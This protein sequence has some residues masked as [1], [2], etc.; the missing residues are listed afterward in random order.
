M[1]IKAER[2]GHCDFWFDV[3][4]SDRFGILKFGR[5]FGFFFDAAEGA[6]FGQVIE[7]GEMCELE[8][9]ETAQ[10]ADSLG[11]ADVIA[12][13]GSHPEAARYRRD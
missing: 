9:A 2:V 10:L 1:L 3:D 6:W 5:E 12:W 4:A 13:F 7:C 11:L 8:A